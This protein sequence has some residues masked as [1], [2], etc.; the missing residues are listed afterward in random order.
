M[1]LKRARKTLQC[2]SHRGERLNAIQM[3]QKEGE[4]ELVEKVPK[5]VKG[6]LGQYD[7]AMCVS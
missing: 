5:E 7:Q 3:R 1:E 6:R 4:N 2:Y